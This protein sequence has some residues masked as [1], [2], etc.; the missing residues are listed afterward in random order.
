VRAVPN[1]VTDL[2]RKASDPAHSVWVSANAGSGKTHVLA[3][4][5]LRLL[6]DGVPPA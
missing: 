4:R 1:H 5:V 3:T 2:Q 6:L